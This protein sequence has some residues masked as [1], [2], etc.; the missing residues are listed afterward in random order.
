MSAPVSQRKAAA[1]AQQKMNDETYENE[2]VAAIQDGGC[3]D[4]TPLGSPAEDHVDPSIQRVSSSEES[5][6]SSSESSDSD[7]DMDTGSSSSGSAVQARGRRSNQGRLNQVRQRMRQSSS[8]SSSSSRANHAQ[9]LQAASVLLDQGTS[10]RYAPPPVPKSS[11][12]RVP[13]PKRKQRPTAGAKRNSAK[14]PSTLV[15]IEALMKEHAAAHYKERERAW[16]GAVHRRNT[17]I[18]RLELRN[19]ALAGEKAKIAQEN[20]LLKVTNAELRKKL[21]E[22]KDRL[23]QVAAL[24]QS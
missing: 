16:N 12:Q 3:D 22:L 15:K 24:L 20:A 1:A 10:P 19:N 2:M 17:K 21:D 23:D 4:I 13:K 9:V 11:D 8:S 5:D 18:E 7:S 6:F 14:R